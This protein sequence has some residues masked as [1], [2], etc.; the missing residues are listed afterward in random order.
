METL[1]INAA[2]K[3]ILSL[4]NTDDKATIYDNWGDFVSIINRYNTY[5]SISYHPDVPKAMYMYIMN[6]SSRRTEEN[7]I[8]AI[9]TF[10][11][12]MK[13]VVEETESG[14][15]KYLAYISLLL[16][17]YKNLFLNSTS[18]ALFPITKPKITESARERIID[19]GNTHA[20][21][22][23]I[24]MYI[25]SVID[26]WGIHSIGDITIEH[27]FEQDTIH[28]IENINNASYDTSKIPNGIDVLYNCY[29]RMNEVGKC[30]I[31]VSHTS[32]TEIYNHTLGLIPKDLTLF[33][34]KYF[35]H[36]TSG[37]MME[38]RLDAVISLN[39]SNDYM[40]ITNS[41]LDEK[42]LSSN[43]C[44]PIKSTNVR[45]IEQHIEL[46]FKMHINKL[47]DLDNI[48]MSMEIRLQRFKVTN[49]IFTFIVGEKGYM[50]TLDLSG[51]AK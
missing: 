33:T 39:L 40:V 11:L 41:G 49:I 12:L 23:A 8:R 37:K 47:G 43:L 4:N 48:P 9:T 51:I 25:K 22:D 28:F 20:Y 26:K 7:I 36:E 3:L 24:K 30:P 29:D 1:L 50:R 31:F 18:Y 27:K 6:F 42:Y 15:I 21:F 46:T 10:G 34:E 44:L 19:Y 45:K 38:G 16:S 35:L 13:A 14:K 2:R 32:N 5:D 17:R